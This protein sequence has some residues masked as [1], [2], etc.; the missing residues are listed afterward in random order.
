MIRRRRRIRRG[1][2][3]SRR[4]NVPNDKYWGDGDF[5]P[6]RLRGDNTPRSTWTMQCIGNGNGQNKKRQ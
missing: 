1:R 4:I 2:R 3:I 5:G 6:D